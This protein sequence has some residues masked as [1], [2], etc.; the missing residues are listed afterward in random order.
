MFLLELNGKNTCQ[1]KYVLKRSKKWM[2]ITFQVKKN[3]NSK[4]WNTTKIQI[5]AKMAAVNAAMYMRS[6]EKEWILKCIENIVLK[7]LTGKY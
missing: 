1:L 4:P 5:H 7:L 6:V 3:E 2:K